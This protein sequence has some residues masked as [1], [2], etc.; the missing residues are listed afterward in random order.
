MEEKRNNVQHKDLR[1]W[2]KVVESI[3]ELKVIER[4][5]RDEDIGP[6]VSMLASSH[7]SPAIL[8][9]KINRFP[10]GYRVL[11]NC[12]NSYKRISLT[13]GFPL[14]LNPF[15]LSTRLLK[16]IEDLKLIPPVYVDKGPVMENILTGKDVNVLKFPTPKWHENDGGRYIGTGTF[17]IIKDPDSDWVNLGTYRVMLFEETDKVGFYITPGKHGYII[18]EKYF[19]QGKPCPVAAVVGGDPLLFLATSTEIPLGVCEYDW[20]GGVRGRPYEVFKGEITGLPLPA[21]AEIILEGFSPPDVK[22]PEGPF[23]EW[24]GYYGGGIE[25]EPIIE[26]KA[27]YHRDD[28]IILGVPPQRPP[29]EQTRFRAVFRSAL[30]KKEL[31]NAGIPGVVEC[32]CHEVGGTRLLLAVSIKQSYLGQAR[33]V[34]HVA[35]QCRAGA[36]AGRYVVVV[37]E[38]VDV[39]DLN[40]VIWAMCTRSDP[41]TSI[42]IIKR[43]WSSRIDPM[44]SPE[45]RAKGKFCNS[46]AIIDATRPWEWKDAFPKVNAPTRELLAKTKEKWGF[47]LKE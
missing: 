45:D 15:E 9:D 18:R 21:D 19:S 47:L 7:T 31:E 39:T 16:L 38:D 8:F 29:D 2:L 40:E 27:I 41:E 10:Q 32:W 46:R 14:D 11:G 6:I 30:L 24:P 25:K 17:D 33:Q 28:P 3:G 1:E 26:V 23:G 43:A 13:L 44:I 22:H 35:S 34:G 5:D 37:D 20:A 36:Y 12:L 4:V 42:D